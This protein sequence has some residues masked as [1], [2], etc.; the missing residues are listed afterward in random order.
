MKQK[1]GL[2]NLIAF[3]HEITSSVDKGRMVDIFILTLARLFILSPITF[4]Q[5]Y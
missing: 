5:T 3:Y 2:T 1:S 4:S